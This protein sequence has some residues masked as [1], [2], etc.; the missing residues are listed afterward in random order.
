VDRKRWRE[1]EAHEDEAD[2]EKEAEEAAKR[3]KYG[4][5]PLFSPLLATREGP[6]LSALRA[7]V[8]FGIVRSIVRCHDVICWLALQESLIQV[9]QFPAF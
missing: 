8:S 1:K 6:C 3:A 5:S 7:G 2:R 9:T 4:K